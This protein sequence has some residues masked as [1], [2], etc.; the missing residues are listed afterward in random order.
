M[1]LSKFIFRIIIG[2]ASFGTQSIAESK[3]E[4]S[5]VVFSYAPAEQIALGQL[6]FYDPVLSGNQNIACSTCHHPKF[7]TSDGVSLSIG[8]GGLGLGPDRMPT[9]L[10]IPEQRI[11]R[12]APALFNLGATE[13]TTLFHDGRL[14]VDASFPSGIRTP[15]DDEMVTGFDSVLSAQAMFP[16][17]SGDEMAGHYS[18]NDI[19]QA[20]RQGLLAYEGGAWDIIAMR[21]AEIPEYSD[22][23]ESI[24]GDRQIR[25]TDISNMIAEFIAFEWRADNSPFDQYLAGGQLSSAA[26]SGMDL[27]YGKA[28]CSACHSGRFQTDHEFHAIAMPQI[29]PGKA[30]RFESHNRDVGRMRVTGNIEDAYKF[31]T[32]SLRNIIQTAPYGH[33]GA[34]STLE[35]VVRHHLDPLKALLEYDRS[36][37]V[38]PNL[39]GARDWGVLDSQA[40]VAEIAKANELD[41]VSL[42]DDEVGELM[43]FLNA[44]T[45][46]SSRDG[47]LG[48]PVSVPSGLP[49][50]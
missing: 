20:V 41:V 16:V 23:F 13:F 25:F 19:A 8:E 34:Y 15:L 27:F 37:V 45:D 32:P 33:D 26:R 4:F 40:E 14:E 17:L 43:A 9:S 39:E 22:K 11:G 24:I 29:G 1:Q 44:L 42:T 36:Q 12:N 10:N 46:E 30:A 28:G 31:R 50:D 47:R 5:P 38:L 18:E 35:G 48:I 21:V 2:F 6:L 49:M 7:G 3:P